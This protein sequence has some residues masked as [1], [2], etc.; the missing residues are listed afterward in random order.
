MS[1]IAISGASGFVGT[2]LQDYFYGKDIKV[3]VIKRTDLGDGEVL[4]EKIDKADVIINLAGANIIQRWSKSHK[5][6]MYRSRINSTKSLVDA[7][8]ASEKEQLLISTSA[9]GIYEN[10]IVMDEEDFVYGQTF[11]TDLCKD[12]EQE[13]SKVEKKLA[14]FRFGV[15]LGEGGALKKMLPPFKLGLGG[16]IGDGK[17]PFSCIHIEDLA[18]AYTY[19]IEQKL[20]GIFN[21]TSPNVTS[22]EH[23]S[24]ALAKNLHRPAF[25]PVPVFALKLLFGEGA[26]VL[27]DGQRVVPKR[28]LDSGFV[29]KYADVETILEDLL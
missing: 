25:I 21:L 19:V 8:N 22:N 4:Q 1:V 9:I 17:Q 28:L 5:K 15:I 27:S 13:A 6:K 24:K 23:F 11:L 12:W 3:I 16:V 20:E 2:Y 10:D 29:F 18:R 26:Q 14:I 7:I